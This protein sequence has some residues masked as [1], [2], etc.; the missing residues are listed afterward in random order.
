[1][2]DNV[3]DAPRTANAVVNGSDEDKTDSF[4]HI[5]MPDEMQKEYEETLSTGGRGD[6]CSAEE[7]QLR[8]E[9]LAKYSYTVCYHW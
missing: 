2:E 3:K 4:V 1:M 8:V 6:F 5:T 7:D 9:P